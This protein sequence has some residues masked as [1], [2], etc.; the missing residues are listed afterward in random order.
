M[1]YDN[2]I[3]EAAL[4]NLDRA[5]YT[6]TDSHMGMIGFTGARRAWAFPIPHNG[7]EAF[8][9]Q[10]SRPKLVWNKSREVTIA[11]ASNGSFE[12]SN[13]D[14]EFHYKWSDP[15]IEEDDPKVV[16][17]DNILLYL[18]TLTGPA[19]VAGQVVLALEPITF[20]ENFR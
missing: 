11:V 17:T 15:E 8:L 3:Y 14:V 12:T 20:T 4:K 5:V 7:N 10:Q 16:P 18:Q 1:V 19:K 6:E 9:N 13:L 2:Y